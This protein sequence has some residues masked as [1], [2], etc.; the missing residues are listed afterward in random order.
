M[1]ENPV[2]EYMFAYPINRLQE[3]RCL[4]MGVRC[5][6]GV[7]VDA[8]KDN[9]NVKFDGIEGNENGTITYAANVCLETLDTSTLSLTFDNTDDSPDTSFTLEVDPLLAGTEITTVTCRLVGQTCVVIVTGT[10]QKSGF[11]GSEL[12]GFTVEFRDGP[13]VDNVQSFDIPGFFAQTGAEPVPAGSIIG[14]C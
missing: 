1:V 5:S 2:Y 11:G 8:T 6:C 13:A 7:L 9:V 12:L 14:T 4:Y 3:R 10:G